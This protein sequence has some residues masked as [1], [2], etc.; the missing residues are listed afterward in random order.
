VTQV[1][2]EADRI[3]MMKQLIRQYFTTRR[4]GSP[5]RRIFVDRRASGTDS[6]VDQDRWM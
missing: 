5:G 2:A 3:G 6:E 4:S 1:T